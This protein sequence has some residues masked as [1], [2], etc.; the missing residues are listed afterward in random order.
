MQPNQP[1]CLLINTSHTRTHTLSLDPNQY[2][3]QT[4]A[5]RRS[6][7]RTK[8]YFHFFFFFQQRIVW[9][10]IISRTKIHWIFYPADLS[11]SAGEQWNFFNRT[12]LFTGGRRLVK[13]AT[14]PHLFLL[15]VFSC[16]SAIIY[17]NTFSVSKDSVRDFSPRCIKLKP[18]IHVIKEPAEKQVFGYQ[19]LV[20]VLCSLDFGCRRIQQLRGQKK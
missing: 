8:D 5:R 12:Q 7:H 14:L 4:Y 15:F 6:C 11:L 16:D 18:Y 19:S 1:L 3:Q 10:F 2:Y 20:C 9:H 17:H 13:K